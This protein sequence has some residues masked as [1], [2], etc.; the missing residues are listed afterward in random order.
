MYKFVAMPGHERSDSDDAHLQLSPT[1]TLHGYDRWSHVYDHGSNPMITATS[2]VLD[3]MALG[4]ANLDVLELGCGTGRNVWRVLNEGARS[5]TGIDGSAGMLAVASQH[6]VDAR[7]KFMQA[8]LLSPWTLEKPVD[9]ALMVLVLEHLPT[10]DAVAQTLAHVVKAGGRI[11]IVDLH[12][13]RVANGTLAHFTEAG[14]EVW[15]ASVS[16]HVPTIC[17]VLDDAGFDVVRRD[18]L[19]TD[20]L[21]TGVPQLAKHRGLKVLLDIKGTRRSKPRR[22]TGEQAALD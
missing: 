21:L 19:A 16:H 15:F 8:D 1:E 13:E 17:D 7:V 5:Y 20:A 22:R 6:N 3:R 14:T 4:A 18:W 12:P 10:L 9:L 2:W 11:R